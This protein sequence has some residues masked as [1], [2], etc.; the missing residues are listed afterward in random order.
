MKYHYK[1]K[2]HEVTIDTTWMNDKK[3]DIVCKKP[4]TQEYILYDSIYMKYK[5]RQN[6]SL[7]IKIRAVVGWAGI[8]DT[9]WKGT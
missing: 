6:S 8:G 2:K 5:N 1:I 7:M 3:Y 4:D 9:Y